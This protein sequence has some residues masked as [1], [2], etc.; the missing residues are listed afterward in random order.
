[1]DLYNN[2]FEV[3]T[4]QVQCVICDKVERIEDGSL[5][6][7]QLYNRKLQSYLCK[8]CDN[9]IAENTRKRHETGKF[10]L[11]SSNNGKKAQK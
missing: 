1:V 10:N 4:V 3:K 2:F 7:K 8:T 9:R 11:Y 6:A 5:Q